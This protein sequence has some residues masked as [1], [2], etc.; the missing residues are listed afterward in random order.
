MNPTD[1]LLAWTQRALPLKASMSERMARLLPYFAQHIRYPIF[2]IAGTNGKGSTAAMLS[3]A[4]THAGK[5]PMLFTSP[6]LIHLSERFR[7]CDTDIRRKALEELAAEVLA[8]LQDFVAIEGTAYTPSFFE[9]LVCMALVY[10]DREGADIA[11][12]EAGVGGFN[13]ATHLLPDMGGAITSVGLDHAPQLGAT[14][15][16]IAHDKAGIVQP[17][18]TLI[19]GVALP[20]TAQ[21][22]IATV[23][24]DRNVTIKEAT[25]V[26][27]RPLNA[28]AYALTWAQQTTTV[29]LPLRGTFQR[30][31]LQL[32]ARIWAYFIAKGL[33]SRW[34]DLQGIA[35]TRWA[36]RLEMLGHAPTFLLDA[37]HN[38][39]A[40]AALHQALTA[41]A[42]PDDCLLIVGISAEKDVAA[43]A[44]WLK[45]LARGGYLVDDFYKSRP[46]ASL[47]AHFPPD[48][49]QIRSLAEA[50]A[51][52]QQRA[53]RYLIVTG[54]IFML[55]AARPLVLSLLPQDTPQ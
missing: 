46:A 28:A 10:A 3:A 55:G 38:E 34:T 44:P 13:D 19:L 22:A 23:A 15:A 49:W 6:H 39:A 50:L 40:L 29:E 14:V 32:V 12:I 9:A 7:L 52:G 16:A 27:C 30:D 47:Q 11:L 31:N 18:S 17:R 8:R 33:V 51:E 48:Q 43:M 5:R 21:Q 1:Q 37:A 54:S 20:P 53:P 45:Q 26:E 36:G 24:Q 41:F 35:H 4:L 2:K 42:T 25:Y